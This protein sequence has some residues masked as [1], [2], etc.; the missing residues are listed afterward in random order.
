MEALEQGQALGQKPPLKL[1]EIWAIR[2]R[3][4]LARRTRDRALFSLEQEWCQHEWCRS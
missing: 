1:R 2:I 4:Q 3:L